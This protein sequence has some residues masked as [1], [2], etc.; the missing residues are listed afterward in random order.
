MTVE[1]ILASETPMG[2]D[3]SFD[4][5]CPCFLLEGD[6]FRIRGHCWRICKDCRYSG[7][8]ISGLDFQTATAVGI[9]IARNNGWSGEQQVIE[10]GDHTHVSGGHTDWTIHVEQQPW[11]DMKERHGEMI[12]ALRK[13]VQELEA[14]LAKERGIKELDGGNYVTLDE[15]E[16]QL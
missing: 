6:G 9:H 8:H 10:H 3:P 2:L 13:Q 5:S 15:L 12:A 1:E 16:Q 14:A 4:G 11:Y 7:I